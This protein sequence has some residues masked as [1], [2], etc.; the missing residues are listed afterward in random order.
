MRGGG[1][2]GENYLEEYRN[3][4]CSSLMGLGGALGK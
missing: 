1:T 3:H 2:I 4:A